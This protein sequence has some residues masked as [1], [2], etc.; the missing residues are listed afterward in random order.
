MAQGASQAK[1]PRSG[2]L[3]PAHPLG[4]TVAESEAKGDRRAELAAWLTSP[5][6]PW[7]AKSFVNRVWF[8]MLGQGFYMPVD[9]LGPERTPQYPAALDALAQLTAAAKLKNRP[10]PETQART[11]LIH[12]L[13]NHNDFVT[14]R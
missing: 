7:F 9:D 14:V 8:E 4:E 11:N 3:I 2:E 10:S 12:A 13:V 1:H 5:K 6:N